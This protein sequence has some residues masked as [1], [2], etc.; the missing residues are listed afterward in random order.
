MVGYYYIA[1]NGILRNAS[2]LNS[3]I[4]APKVDII[5]TSPPYVTSYEYADLHQLSSLW[6]DYT[7]DYRE[8]REGSI[9]SLYHEYNFNRELKRL[10][11]TGNKIVSHL[12][13]Q[14]KSKARS[15]AKYLLDMQKVTIKSLD[16]LNLSSSPACTI[17]YQYNNL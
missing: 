7:K 15:V 14:H 4:H 8:L 13:D 12:L 10:N 2:S 6:L 11:T 9:G 16:M 1:K 5:I 3:S 17:T